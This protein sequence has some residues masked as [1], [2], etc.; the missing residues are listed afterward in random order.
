M[1][2]GNSNE[3]CLIG[4]IVLFGNIVAFV[5]EAYFPICDKDMYSILITQISKHYLTINIEVV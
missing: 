1:F 5:I 4:Y 2:K 3:L